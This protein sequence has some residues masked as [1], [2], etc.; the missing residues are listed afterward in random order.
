MANRQP[1]KLFEAYGVELEYM[2]VEKNTLKVMPI[3][4]LLFKEVAGSI[5]ADID[6]GVISW[7]NELVSHVVELKVSQP[8]PKLE[9]LATLFHQQV[10]RINTVLAKWNA[11]LLPTG[12]H[13]F[14]NPL[15][16][17]V[18]WPHEYHEIYALYNRVFDCRGH[19]WSNLQST[20]INLPFHGDQ[21]FG[22]L[23]AAIRLLMPII[24]ALSA[25][26]PLLEGQATGFLDSR[27]EVYRHNQAKIPSL[28]GKVVPEPVF[29]RDA[30]QQVIFDRIINDMRPYDHE[31]IMDH[32]F[33]NSRGAIAR[34]DRGAI[35]IRIIDIQERPSADMAILKLIS[36]VLKNLVAETW[37]PL[38]MQQHWE[39]Q[40]LADLLVEVIR[41]GENAQLNQTSYLRNFGVHYPCTA[42]E[43]W[44]ELL[45]ELEGNFTPSELNCL[46]VILNQG[47]LSSRILRALQ[48]Q[49]EQ[50]NIQDL[51][52]NLALCLAEDTMFT[53]G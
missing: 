13:P 5:V 27:L 48:G 7:S 38:S 22:R 33:L 45:G 40:G 47:T 15:T 14:M 10:Q 28:A 41:D 6:A 17:T 21:E 32:H 16:E 31:G 19:G 36:L 37:T 4:D 24:P 52:R 18:I 53:V 26:S 51:Y 3:A 1:L 39:T 30:Y 42:G 20:H 46:H 25:S 35:E 2:I 12:A 8:E 43:L 49:V 9:G 29:T 44:E 11:C 50:E 34:F 23:H